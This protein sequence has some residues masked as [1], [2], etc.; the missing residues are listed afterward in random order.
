MATQVIE[1]DTP[2]SNEKSIH[3]YWCSSPSWIDKML[4]ESYVTT[5]IYAKM[6]DEDKDK[7]IDKLENVEF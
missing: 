2:I 7:A 4:W 5:Q 3:I 6:V 1:E